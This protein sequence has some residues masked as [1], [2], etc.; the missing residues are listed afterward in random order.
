MIRPMFA[1][2]ALMISSAAI[3][4]TAPRAPGTGA[5]VPQGATVN[6]QPTEATV[7]TPTAGAGELPRCSRTVTHRCIQI[8]NGRGRKMSRRKHRG[9]GHRR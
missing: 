3:A 9:G 1:A 5:T 6:V 4:Q 8:E 2:M 7:S